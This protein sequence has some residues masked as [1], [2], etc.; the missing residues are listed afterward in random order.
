LKKSV[1]EVGL[2]EDQRQDVPAKVKQFPH[3]IDETLQPPLQG[4]GLS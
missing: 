3:M 4:K 2:L 1:K